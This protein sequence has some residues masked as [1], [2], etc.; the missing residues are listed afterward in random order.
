MKT[1]TLF[2]DTLQ[3]GSVTQS[4]FDFPNCT[5]EFVSKLQDENNHVAAYIAFSIQSDKLLQQSEKEWQLFIAKEEE[6]FT[7]LIESDKWH[8]IDERGELTNILIPLFYE[9]G[10][11]VWRYRFE[12]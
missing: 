4:G 1:Y 9:D 5:G 12:D 8:M 11:V 6:Q 7:D 3:L 2:Y 10:Q